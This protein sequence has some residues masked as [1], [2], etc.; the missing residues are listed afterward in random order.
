MGL[1]QE[2]IKVPGYE[3][4]V[5][6]TEERSGLVAIVAV[7]NTKLGPGLGGTRIYPY[8]SFDQALEDVLR[9]SQG[10][11]Y[12][13]GIAQLGVGGAKSVIIA[14]PKV[15]KTPELFRAFGECVNTF[16]GKY[17]CAEDVGCTPEDVEEIAKTTK[18]VCG[19]HDLGGG[20]NPAV[21]TAWGTLCGIRAVFQQLDGMD[22][23]AGKTVAI[24]GLGNVGGRL[25]EH[26][27]W[28][29]AK[30]IISDLDRAVVD[31]YAHAYGAKAV[32][33]EE[34]MCTECDVLSPCA[35]G[36]VITVDVIPH[37]RCRAIAG[38][39]NN[40]LLHQYDAD[41]LSERKI[42]YAPDFLVNAGG[43]INVVNELSSEG[44]SAIKAKEMTEEIFG[45]LLSIFE[46]AQQQ[47][48]SAYQ[49]A[50]NL[51]DY[52]IQHRIGR[53]IDDLCFRFDPAVVC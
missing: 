1:T 41:L 26:L 20:G 39:A 36:N 21:F 7:H 2:V 9:L 18:Y 11:T 8:A 22:S 25:V 28:R 38:A 35:M 34:I 29:D 49:A 46:I 15:D 12:K 5:K 37:L 31:Y 17:I 50:V 45:R 13:A 44:Y 23:I 14:D 47:N 30:I 48:I 3:R 4:V 6:F 52:H 24:Q 19:V 16:E 53:R 27:F 51:V 33:P 43:L 40:Q 10:M 32:A 42:L